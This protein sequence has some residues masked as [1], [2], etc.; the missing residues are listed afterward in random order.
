[1]GRKKKIVSDEPE[2]KDGEGVD[3]ETPETPE[4]PEVPEPSPE[5]LELEQLYVL[6][7]KYGANSIS[8]EENKLARA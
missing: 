8:D 3:G 2:I 4:V 6:M 1:M 7:K 5:K